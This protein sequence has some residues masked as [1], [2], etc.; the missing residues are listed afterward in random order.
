M[1]SAR[2]AIALGAIAGTIAVIVWW[3]HPP[4]T[5]PATETIECV[6]YW[7]NAPA[8][9]RGAD[10]ADDECAVSVVRKVGT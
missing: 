9:L 8:E 2:I 10:H 1:L 5:V 6:L 3:R 4:A 7:K